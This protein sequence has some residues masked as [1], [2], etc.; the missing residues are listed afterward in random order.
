MKSITVIG[1]GY[2]GLS[3]AAL[4]SK[5]NK[6][7]VVDISENK[8][9]KLKNNNS[10]IS[11]ENLNNLLLE[12][13][14]NLKFDTKINDTVSDIY[15]VATSTNYDPDKQFFD[16]SSVESV[17]KNIFNKFGNVPIA[18]KSTV[19]VGFTKS[20][21]ERYKSKEIFFS[22]EFLR[23][24]SAIEDNIYPSRIIVGSKENSGKLFAT[25]LKNISKGNPP[26][27]FMDSDTAE[28]VKLFSNC[29]LAMRVSFFNELDSFAIEKNLDSKKLIEGVSYDPRIGNTYN[30][31]SFGYGGY[32]LPKDAK[33]LLANYADVPQNLIEAVVKANSTRKDYISDQIINKNPK[34][35]GIYRLVMKSGSDNF[36]ESAIQGIMKRLNAKNILIYVYE[37]EMQEDSFFGCEV[38]KDL[39]EFIET[40]DLIVAN[41]VSDELNNCKSKVYSRDL[42]KNN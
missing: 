33:Q 12:N 41:R 29:F 26:I 19:P 10:H 30:N 27:Q 25:L 22:P 32:C 23:E 7:L 4:L 1:A 14:V 3:L 35:V 18:I 13:S 5:N 37:P 39:D 2:V 9:Q 8:I 28:S 40:S 34:S 17:I 36:R 24:G 15:I 42:F 11:E 21:Q 16:T 31:P 20:M 38:I 6:V